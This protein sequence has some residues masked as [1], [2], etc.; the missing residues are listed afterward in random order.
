MSEDRIRFCCPGCQQQL[1]TEASQAGKQVVCP[2]CQ[3]ILVAPAATIPRAEAPMGAA[4]AD[5]LAFLATD[6]QA[7][8]DARL[9][10]AGI[11]PA[12]HA[13]LPRP[14]ERAIPTA[15]VVPTASIPPATVRSAEPMV[16]DNPTV[17]SGA[18]LVEAMPADRAIPDAAQS[19]GNI[20]YI[21]ILCGCAASFLCLVA[22]LDLLSIQSRAGDSI[23][24]AIAHGIGIYCIGQAFF[25]GPA[26]AGAGVILLAHRRK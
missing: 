20:A 13:Q 9:R 8:S 7:V 14:P 15:P 21:L 2:T 4:G 24:E 3:R 16:L 5:P 23:F 11:P 12:G 1:A 25:G 6:S 19:T 18:P 17:V 10:S 26:L 22:G